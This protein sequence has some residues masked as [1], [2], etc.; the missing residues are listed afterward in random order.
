MNI[1][2]SKTKITVKTFDEVLNFLSNIPS[3]NCG[4]C[5]ISAL[6]MYRWLKKHGK[7]TE[8]TAF[9][10]LENDYERH[11]NNKGYY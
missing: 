7:T 9:Y 8:E 2:G 1:F 11:N 10:Y 5:G 6:A 4:G 3:I